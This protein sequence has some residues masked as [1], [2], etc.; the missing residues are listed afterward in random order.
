MKKLIVC[1]DSWLSPVLDFPGTHFSEIFAKEL[2]FDLTS[3]AMKFCGNPGIAIQINEAIKNKPDLIMFL[4]GR[5]DRI[6]IPLKKGEQSYILIDSSENDFTNYPYYRLENLLHLY[7][8]ELSYKNSNEDAKGKFLS[9]R[10][11][12]LINFTSNNRIE[13]L[14]LVH[15]L[16][17]KISVGKDYLNFLYDPHIKKMT[18]CFMMYAVIHKLH[19]SNIPYLWIRDS[20]FTFGHPVDFSWMPSKNKVCELVR[21]ITNRNIVTFGD[22]GFHTTFEG[23]KEVAQFLINH[24]KNN[25]T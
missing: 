14:H 12:D 25:F 4:T 6:E 7:T 1:G 11:S 19:L 16:D 15:D 24:Y 9:I 18:E 22:V 20:L 23:Q 8:R 21:M 2:N 5:F 17:K 10:H 13:N 3:Y